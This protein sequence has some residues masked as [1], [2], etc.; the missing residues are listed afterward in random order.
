MN[1]WINVQMDRCIDA[2]MDGYRRWMDK[3]INGQ[4]DKWIDG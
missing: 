1:K 3:W 4:M 2:Q